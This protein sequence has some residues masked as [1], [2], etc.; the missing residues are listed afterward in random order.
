METEDFSSRVQTL[1]FT[2]EADQRAIEEKG[3]TIALLNDNLQKSEHENV[4]LQA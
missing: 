1:E 3:A 2:N 4:A